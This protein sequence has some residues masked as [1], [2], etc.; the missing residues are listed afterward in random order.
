VAA[1][2]RRPGE[3]DPR[4]ASRDQAPLGFSVRDLVPELV[5]RLGLP[6]SLQGVLVTEVDP[7]GPARLAELR[8]NH[9]V[10]EIGREPVRS[11]AEFRRHVAAIRVGEPVAL[12]VYDRTIRQHRLCIVVP[13]TNP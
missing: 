1:A 9:V 10:T 7:A 6:A 12:L 3:N 8:T 4:P 13:E 2:T 11:V 5:D